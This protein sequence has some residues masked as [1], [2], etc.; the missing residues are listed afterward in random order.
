MDLIKKSGVYIISNLKNDKVYIGSAI[1]INQRFRLHKSL[2]RR[3]KHSNPHLQNSWNKYGS[4][5]FTFNMLIECSLSLLIE[6]EQ[7]VLDKYSY[8]LG[9]D[10]LYNIR[11]IAHSNLGI[12]YSLETRSKMSAAHKNRKRK[13]HSNATKAKMSKAAKGRIPW[14]KGIKTPADVVLKQSIAKKGN[15]Y[16]KNNKGKPKPPRSVEHC[17]NISKALK[18]RYSS[19]P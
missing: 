9:W 5:S 1:D 17:A 14:N 2:L 19:L 7:E 6:Y 15:K 3:K 12:T 8:T 10:S 16:G 11:H 13:P 18:K 4:E